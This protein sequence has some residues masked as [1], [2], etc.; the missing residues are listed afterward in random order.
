MERAIAADLFTL[1]AVPG[2]LF[3]AA[4]VAIVWIIGSKG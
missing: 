2:L 4:V 3:L 1:L